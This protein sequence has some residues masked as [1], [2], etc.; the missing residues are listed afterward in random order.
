M[1][2]PADVMMVSGANVKCKEDALTGEADEFTKEPLTEENMKE[3]V[4][5]VMYAKSTSNAGCSGKGIVLSVGLSTAA[6]VIAKKTT[7]GGSKET[8]L[9]EKLETITVTIGNVGTW[10][11]IL[12]LVAQFVRILLEYFEL[13]PCGCMNMFSCVEVEGCVPYDFSDMGNKVYLELLNAV[14]ISIT[15]VVVAI[16]EGLPLAVTIALSFA[17]AIMYKKNNLVREPASAETMGGA[18]F[19]C[20]DKTGTLTMNQMTVMGAMTCGK[21]HLCP[22]VNETPAFVSAAEQDF[23]T[24]TVGETEKS[25]WET[26][27]ESILWNLKAFIE[28]NTKPVADREA[29]EKEDYLVRGNITDQG[30][31][32]FFR[33]KMDNESLMEYMNKVKEAGKLLHTITF[34]SKRKKASI[35][36]RQPE[37][38]GTDKEVRVYCKGG[39]DFMLRDGLVS[40]IVKDDGSIVELGDNVEEWPEKL[41]DTDLNE[42]AEEGETYED[43]LQ[44]TISLFASQAYRTILTTYRDMSME[45]WEGLADED[46]SYDSAETAAQ[47]ETGL[48]AIGIF[49]LEDPLKPGINKAISDCQTAGIR[50]IMC[51]GDN[52]E[53]ATAISL[54]AGIVDK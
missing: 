34:S 29:D 35:V 27:Q 54:N 11:A 15:V 44:S 52:I 28:K 43:M 46:G 50:V 48:T 16:P 22:S 33:E 12:T 30:C 53:T 6:G 7:E 21:V 24:V 26:L 39:P 38:E 47:I 40:N 18:N 51:T 25:L 5:C 31:V 1:K 3:G 20:S 14:I 41:L 8:P 37:F 2:V 10:M 42:D 17:S 49:G 36:V 13:M 19:V 32:K 9:M 23:A 45:E 4:A